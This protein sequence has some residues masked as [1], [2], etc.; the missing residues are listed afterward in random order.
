MTRL[1]VLLLLL[2]LAAAVVPAAPAVASSGCVTRA[3]YRAVKHGWPKG[4][5][6]HEFGT[7]GHR[8]SIAAAHGY[9]SE[10][11]AYRGCVAHSTVVVS[12]LKKP[13]GVLRLAAKA[14]DW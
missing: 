1:M 11:R 5:V 14:A 6:H 7:K 13:G 2:T 12:Y 9:A 4:R 10:V 3:E 8:L